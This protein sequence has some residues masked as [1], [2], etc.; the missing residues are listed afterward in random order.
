LG[1]ADV[2]DGCRYQTSNLVVKSGKFK[3]A[4]IGVVVIPERGKRKRYLDGV[5]KDIVIYN[6][7]R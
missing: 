3:V 7:G 4:I 2:V 6:N 5:S 1:D